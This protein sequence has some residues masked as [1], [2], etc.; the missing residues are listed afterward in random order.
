MA[1]SRNTTAAVADGARP[2]AHRPLGRGQHPARGRPAPAAD[3][4]AGALG[5][6][7]RDQPG[8][9]AGGVVEDGGG[10]RAG[11]RSVVR[12]SWPVTCSSGRPGSRPAAPRRRRRGT[13]PGPWPWWSG[14]RRPVEARSELRQAMTGLHMGELREG[15]WM[16]PDNLD[17]AAAP[18]ATAV[19]DAQC[20]RFVVAVADIPDAAQPLGG[21]AG[22]ARARIGEA[23]PADHRRA[24]ELAGRLWDLDA[25]DD[26]GRAAASR[27]RRRGGFARVRRHV[28]PRRRVSCSPPPCC[29]TCSPT[30]L[31]PAELLPAGWCGDDL[32]HDYD[33]YDTAFKTL[34][35]DWFRRARDPD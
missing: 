15:V 24:R 17:E 13:A 11:G 16:R 32:R 35:R 9:D 33:R 18:G 21:A 5:R 6:A 22:P 29:A 12:T 10:G 28:G 27:A 31:L 14:G 20:Q 7:V 4:A 3:P 1:Q 8:D 34:W 19:L 30:R 26:A 2:P 23:G 25:L